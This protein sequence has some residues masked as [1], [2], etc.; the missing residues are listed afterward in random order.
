[1]VRANHGW[2]AVLLGGFVCWQL[3]YLPA[4]NTF[5]FVPLRVPADTGD[6]PLNLQHFGRFTTDDRLQ[7]LADA[8]G[9][10]LSRY[11]ELSGQ[12]Q[13][14]KLFT[15][16][17]PSHTFVLVT[18]AELRDGRVIEVVSPHASPIDPPLARL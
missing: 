15:P 12:I 5:H 16:E 9:A 14:W 11:S 4:T 7:T 3:V 2:K 10:G 1:M 8:A 18:K 13:F 17:F 6:V